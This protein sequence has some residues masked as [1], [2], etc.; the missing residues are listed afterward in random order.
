TLVHLILHYKKGDQQVFKTIK[1]TEA[2]IVAAFDDFFRSLPDSPYV[3]PKE[4]TVAG[5][6]QL[7]S[8]YET[9]A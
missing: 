9:Q 1:L 8:R 4:A 3:L 5:L 7:I 6:D 2:N